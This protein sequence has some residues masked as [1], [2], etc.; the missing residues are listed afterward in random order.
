M[1]SF[2]GPLAALGQ[3]LVERGLRYE[4][5]AVGGG[6]LQLLGLISR[7]TRDMDIV[8][9]V[10][11]N[12]LLALDHLPHP[13]TESVADVASVFRIPRDWFNVGPAALMQLGLPPGVLARSQRRE[14]GGLVLHLAERR[15]QIF[16]KL[17]AATDQG[18]N[19][20]HFDDLVRLQPTS[21]EI[22]AAALWARTHDPSEGFAQELKG[23][24]S[25][26]GIDDAES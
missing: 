5:L 19:S 26:L 24:L 8:A 6:A 17:Y 11:G 20:K 25:D 13:M 2:E 4:F 21:N 3:L 14:W 1:D 15:D 18:P 22:R 12:S 16:F 23:A 9:T 10:D 7:S